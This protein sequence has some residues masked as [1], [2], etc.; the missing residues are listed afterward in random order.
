[1]AFGELVAL[2]LYQ[3]AHGWQVPSRHTSV[4]VFGKEIYYGPYQQGP[5]IQ[6]TAPG[7]S[8][9]GKLYQESAI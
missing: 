8:H 2:A 7:R 3:L 6:I 9:V 1:M 5:G 4:V